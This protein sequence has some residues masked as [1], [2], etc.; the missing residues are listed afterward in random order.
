MRMTL[1]RRLL[2]E[3]CWLLICAIVAFALYKLWGVEAG[4]SKRITYVSAGVTGS[5]WVNIQTSSLYTSLLIA[6]ISACYTLR[7]L[8]YRLKDRF[9][10]G[11]IIVMMAIN[12]LLIM[13]TVRLALLLENMMPLEG[14][15]PLKK[16]AI[17]AVVAL[18]V[19]LYSFWIAAY[20]RKRRGTRSIEGPA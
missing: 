12:A 14:R 15:L 20:R 9:L 8:C 4:M 19:V 2:L 1:L 13:G 6:V 18:F 11:A 16:E 5:L 7:S 10:D 3:L 17:W